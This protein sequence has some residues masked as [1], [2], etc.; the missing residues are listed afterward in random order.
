[1]RAGVF[2]TLTLTIIAWTA[3]MP[4][5]AH[6]QTA[7]GVASGPYCGVYSLYT[8]LRSQGVNLELAQLLRPTYV[9]STSGSTL[10]QLRQA[11]QEHQAYGQLLENLSVADLH[12][13]NCPA[14]LH[15]KN[16]YDAP[17][18]NHFLLCVPVAG[19]QLALYDPPGAIVRTAGHELAALWDGTALVV[20]ARPINLASM[21]GWAAARVAL[22][23]AG[24]L[25]ALGILL[26]VRLA[27]RRRSAEVGFCFGLL[28][29][30]GLL[31]VVGAVL[32]AAYHLT[33]PEGFLA[34][35]AA[36]AAII[37]SA[38]TDA[39][40]LDLAQARQLWQRETL[41]VDARHAQ[42]YLQDHIAGAISIPPAASRF[43]RAAALA[44]HAK[45]APLVVYCQSPSCP[46]ARLLARRLN[47]DGFDNV[48]VFAGGW[49]QWRGPS[50]SE[51][52]VSWS[53][54]AK[55][56]G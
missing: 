11:T 55:E 38:A 49:T 48:K 24:A 4:S 32:A 23:V 31:A 46:Y 50:Q 10:S 17:D 13:L 28:T 43:D 53:A 54:V 42:D 34:Q 3:A 7:P 37:A 36:V 39:P 8:A 9:S 16:E 51:V 15:V 1:M 5:L 33:A 45:S 19:G 41:F 40:P 29:Q 18:Y 2:S 22:T 26:F 52:H 20:S 47:R 6:A 27:N 56:G 21:R 30:C 44:G 14:I 35:R 25:A 12:H